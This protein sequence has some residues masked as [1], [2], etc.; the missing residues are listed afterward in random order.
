MQS[1][2]KCICQVALNAVFTI[3]IV[4]PSLVLAGTLRLVY[5]DGLGKVPE[6]TVMACEQ[7]VGDGGHEMFF[8]HQWEMFT[9]CVN[10][11]LNR[12]KKTRS[13]RR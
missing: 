10:A 1:R 2:C 8:D 11:D 5:I 13:K 9:D 3:A 7:S 4:F 12:S 6:Q